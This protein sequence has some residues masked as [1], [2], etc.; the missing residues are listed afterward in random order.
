MITY[1]SERPNCQ[2]CGK[3]MKE[4]TFYSNWHECVECM[5]ERLADRVIKK[6]EETLNKNRTN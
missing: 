3:P 2:T 1:Q 6:I 4:W 5:A